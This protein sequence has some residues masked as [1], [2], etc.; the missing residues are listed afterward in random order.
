MRKIEW[1][2]ITGFVGADYEGVWED[3]PD[4]TTDETLNQWLQEELANYI[5]INWHEIKED[6]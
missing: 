6:K 1:R 2:I 3:V 5:E 4:D